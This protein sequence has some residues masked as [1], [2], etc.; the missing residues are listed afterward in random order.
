MEIHR[1]GE[2]PKNF[3]SKLFNK[4]YKETEGLRRNLANQIDS[5]RYGVTNDIILSWFDDKF[6]FVFTKYMETRDEK[7]LKYSLINALSLFKCRVLRKA[8][9]GEAEIYSNTISIINRENEKDIFDVIPIEDEISNEDLFLELA[10][11]FLKRKLEEDAYLLLELQINPPSFILDRV[12]SKFNITTRVLVEYFS[13]PDT[14]ESYRYIDSLK[15]SIA[16]YTKEAEEHFKSS[17]SFDLV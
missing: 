3:D 14:K 1:L 4:L 17:A 2:I 6:I 10:L 15:E 8:Y 5:R 7:H 12:R 9:G 11:S 16:H 13:L